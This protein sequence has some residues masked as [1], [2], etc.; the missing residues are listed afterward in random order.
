LPVPGVGEI[1]VGCLSVSPI[2]RGVIVLAGEEARD[3]GQRNIGTE[4]LL[5]GMLD[6]GEGIAAQ[7]LRSFGLSADSVREEILARHP[8]L[9][10][11]RF[12]GQV[13]FTPAAQAVLERSLRESLRLSHGYIGTEHLLLGLIGE[14]N[15]LAVI[16]LNTFD[17]EPAAVSDAVARLI[18]ADG[19]MV[20]RR[21]DRG[22]AQTRGRMSDWLSVQPSHPIRRLLV[23]A[24]GSAD[25]AGHSQI[26]VGELL[27]AASSYM[28]VETLAALGIDADQLRRAIERERQAPPRTPASPDVQLVRAQDGPAEHDHGRVGLEPS[29]RVRQL[30]IAAGARALDRGSPVIE[31]S[32]LLLALTHDNQTA[33]TLTALGV[34]VKSLRTTIERRRASDPGPSVSPTSDRH[35]SFSVVVCPP[36]LNH[37]RISD[38]D[39]RAAAYGP[40]SG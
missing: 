33:A 26:E 28:N 24:A 8:W 1:L 16:I 5:L 2:A 13:P 34:D 7:A 29:E 18:G 35:R 17:V 22:F 20:F 30:L 12:D 23:T 4:H 36:Q 6:E 38:A 27:A 37:E 3:S 25:M 32:D 40:H 39:P 10:G 31:I 15:G 21:R 9:T 11:D 14:N 19:G